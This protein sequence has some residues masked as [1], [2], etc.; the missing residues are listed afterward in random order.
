M[1]A[2]WSARGTHRGE[3]QGFP[4]KAHGVPATGN[5]VSFSATDIYRIENG[6]VAEEWIGVIEKPVL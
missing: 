2:R 6:M 3:F 4:P 5:A 1:A